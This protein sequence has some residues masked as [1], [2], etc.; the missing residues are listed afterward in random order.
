MLKRIVLIV[1]AALLILGAGGYAFYRLT[2]WP[3][4]WLIRYTF[5]K[6]DEEARLSAAP[7]VPKAGIR[8]E[9][10]LVYDPMVPDGRFDVFAPTDSK[11]PLPAIVWVHGGGFVAGSREGV[12]NY[13]QVLASLGYV[14]VAI[15]YTLAPSAKFPTPVSQTNAALDHIILNASKFNI[16]PMRI[17]LMG[18]SAGAHIVAQTAL[19]I[20]DSSYAKRIGVTPG[21]RRD[22]L[23]G[24]ILHCGMYNPALTDFEGPYGD[25]NRTVIWSYVGTR[26]H[27]D[28]RVQQL[29]VTPFV[30]ASFPPTFISAGNA[31]PL[32]P[33]SAELTNALRSKEVEVDS[34]FFPPNHQPPLG[35][36]YQMMLS[37]HAGRLA[38]DRSAAFL[39]AH[40]R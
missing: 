6:S 7:F 8:A 25:F 11:S 18:D 12:G 3:S 10:G 31:D 23:R 38:F 33:Q 29:A 22:Q 24:L 34:L 15:D 4:V 30:T 1:L 17:F 36:E 13:L 32:A 40:S 14:G 39:A 26:N 37:T 2:P 5:A 27:K 28:L 21:L 19:A 16:D 9:R 20:S 35:H